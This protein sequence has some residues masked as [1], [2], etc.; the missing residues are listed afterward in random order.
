MKL[1][2]KRGDIKQDI[3]KLVLLGKKKA[4]LYGTAETHVIG[5]ADNHGAAF[6]CLSCSSVLRTVVNYQNI[7]LWNVFVSMPDYS[8]YSALFIVGRNDYQS[9]TQQR[10]FLW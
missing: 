1:S 10:F 4:A 9:F 8:C 6:P 2:T 5:K 7:C 3:E